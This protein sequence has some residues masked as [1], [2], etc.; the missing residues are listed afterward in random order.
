M[1]LLGFRRCKSSIVDDNGH[2]RVPPLEWRDTS[3]PP[4]AARRDDIA[5]SQDA[6]FQQVAP[7]VSLEWDDPVT[8]QLR[9]RGRL[10]WH[11]PVRTVLLVKKWQAPE[12]TR[13]MAEVIRWLVERGVRVQVEQSVKEA[14]VRLTR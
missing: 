9:R 10:L 1:A 2:V 11:R 12:A 7:G 8:M 6:K 13:V 14:E 4:L 5:T 3:V